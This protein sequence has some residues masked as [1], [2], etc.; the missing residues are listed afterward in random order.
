MNLLDKRGSG[1]GS[2][3]GSEAS[4]AHVSASTM[5]YAAAGHLVPKILGGLR[6]SVPDARLG[7][8]SSGYPGD[9]TGHDGLIG[10][11][12]AGM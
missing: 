6:H 5:Q 2:G 9:R 11:I 1:S 10:Y 8:A 3:S 7:D 4:A 12:L